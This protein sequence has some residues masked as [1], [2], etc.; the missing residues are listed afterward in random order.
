[1]MFSLP[2]FVLVA[3]QTTFD[4]ATAG[5]PCSHD[6]NNGDHCDIY[7]PWWVQGCCCYANC[8]VPGFGPCSQCGNFGRAE[9]GPATGG[10]ETVSNGFRSQV[11][12]WGAIAFMGVVL[13]GGVWAYTA[14][15]ADEKDLEEQ[16][17]LVA[18]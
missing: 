4:V 15:K 10:A 17:K 7:M 5:Q 13:F 9:A 18:M 16:V 1:M 8:Y 3:L 12:L 2:L 14:R 6:A 11:V